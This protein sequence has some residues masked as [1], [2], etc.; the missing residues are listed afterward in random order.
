MRYAHEDWESASGKNFYFVEERASV[1]A[2]TTRSIVTLVRIVNRGDSV[3]SRKEE[4]T[5]VSGGAGF[6]FIRWSSH[7]QLVWPWLVAGGAPFQ[8]SLCRSNRKTI[9]GGCW[10]PF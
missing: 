10:K 6:W 3:G 2:A 1:I 4:R 9:E 8:A 7:F 5:L